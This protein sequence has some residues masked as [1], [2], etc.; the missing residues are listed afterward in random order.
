MITGFNT[1]VK[2]AGV[3][4]HVQTEDKGTGNPCIESLVY[5]GGQI[6]ARKR[7]GYRSLLEE[8]GNAKAVAELM[9]RQHQSLIA[10]IRAGKMDDKVAAIKGP[11]K[12]A[13]S[14]SEPR[15]APV[16]PVQPPKGTRPAPAR[17]PEPAPPKA[18]PPRAETRPPASAPP[19]PAAPPAQAA[20][21]VDASTAVPQSMPPIPEA[22]GVRPASPT[23]A[24]RVPRQVQPPSPPQREPGTDSDRSLDQVILDYLE[25]ESV[26]DRLVLSLHRMAGRIAAGSEATIR[27]S[28]VSSVDAD[29]IGQARITVSLISTMDEPLVLGEG[30]TNDQGELELTFLIPELK[31]GSGA[32]IVRAESSIGNAESRHLI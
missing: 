6:L 4:F 3:V 8:A 2:H 23:R 32:L 21:P 11:R 19:E 25:M 24:A 31:T 28:T 22:E 18:A 10:E 5:V 13:E 14:S 1:D 15:P 17:P 12:P 29:P 20:P 27:F 30:R 9:E 26:Q 16:Q 7:A